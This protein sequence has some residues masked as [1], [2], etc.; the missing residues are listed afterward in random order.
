MPCSSDAVRTANTARQAFEILKKRPPGVIP[1]VGRRIVA[2]AAV[3]AGNPL[4]V[5]SIIFDYEGQVAY[6]TAALDR[7]DHHG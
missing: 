6:D 3:F 2:A 4:A 1:A 5:R 7:E